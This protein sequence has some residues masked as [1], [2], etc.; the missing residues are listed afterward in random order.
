MAIEANGAM[1]LSAQ[2]LDTVAG[3]AFNVNAAHTQNLTELNLGT[4]EADRNGVRSTSFQSTDDFEAAI[5]QLNQ[6]GG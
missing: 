6:T 2:E 3:G 5:A 1:E 4:L